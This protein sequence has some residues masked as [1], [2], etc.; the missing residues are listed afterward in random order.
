MKNWLRRKLLDLLHPA[1][2]APLQAI[3]RGSLAPFNE[4]GGKRHQFEIIDA[5]NGKVLICNVHQHNPN[6]PDRN[7]TEIYLVPPDAD[8]MQT[9][10]TA[11]VSGALQ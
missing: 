1:K 5:V 3:S 10:N 8:L 9:I 11:I 6:G 4:L 7:R 2:E